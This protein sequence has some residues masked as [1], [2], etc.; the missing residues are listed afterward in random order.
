LSP[1]L[2]AQP[3]A[4]ETGGDRQ[5][6]LGT[7]LTAPPL[8]PEHIVRERLLDVLDAATTRP[9]TLL[10]APTGFGKTTLLAAWARRGTRRSAWLTLTD[11]DADTVRLMA[12]IVAA[13]RR[14]GVD[15]DDD[16]DR[17][18][19]APGSDP[20]GR[21]LP[22]LL[23]GVDEGDPLVLIL[24]D[25]HQ[26][27][28]SPAR[29]LITEFIAGLPERLRV[30]IAT[31]ADPA[32]PLGR[33][34]AVGSM[35]EIRSDR[36][37]FDPEEADRF[38]NGSLGLDL[39]P[40][41]VATLEERTEGWPAGLYLAALG[42]RGHL[43]RARFVAEFAG[44]SRHIVDYLSTEV[45][46]GL[47][48][49]DRSFLLK[50]SILRRLTGPLC[51]A[52]TGMTGSSARLRELQR[53][54]L[55]IVAL[56]E[57]GTWFRFHRLFAQLLRSELADE[58][59][60][61]EPEL[62]R[63]ASAWHADHGPVEAAVEH[64]VAAG[65]RALAGSLMVRSWQ[66]FART[67][68]FQTFERLIALIGDDRGAVA[69]PVAVVEAMMAGLQ[70]RNPTVIG[71]LI[72]KAETSG[73]E[74]PTPDGFPIALL[75]DVVVATFV[76]NDLARQKAAAQRLIEHEYQDPGV[77]GTGRAGL[78][79]ILNLEGDA[80]AALAIL[81]GAD[82]LPDHPNV[83]LY[84]AAARS[85]ATTD[86]GDPIEGERLARASLARAEA[87]GLASSM[88]AGSVWF[89]LGS[90]VNQQGKPRN[91]I[92]PLER[93]LAQWGVP[94]TLHRAQVLID[95]ASVYVAV[96]EPV[97]G[98]TAVREARKI[99]DGTTNA[100]ALPTRLA[101]V[102]KRLRIGAARNLPDS[103]VPSEAEL[104]VLRLLATPLSPR[105]I[106]NELYISINTVKTHTKAL[107]QK[108]GTSSREET[109]RRARELGLL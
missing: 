85:L 86:T 72:T 61:L 21:V 27:T 8:R 41:S 18:L 35:Q 14:A 59:P 42:L 91:A 103:D 39:D 69:G 46:Q 87:W 5:I 98:R 22:R 57:Q 75:A 9:L 108:L 50:T 68:E 79:M 34:R 3:A 81:Q 80:P 99:V 90:A 40:A 6:V 55:F 100:G 101:A 66:D 16:L 37:R 77:V 11:G 94:G 83:S 52:V 30:V 28:G 13:L 67:G 102:E 84:A 44:S 82:L 20:A 97:K 78:G 62:H 95:L 56:D 58:S 49:D 76:A 31:R 23:D 47:A 1:T 12:G 36:L 51:D 32:L 33:L 93:A 89:A 48:A 92:P 54:N 74:G 10:S 4:S 29:G 2:T 65:D 70:G 63:R 24:D 38:L 53:A 88:V 106:G 7:K 71:G 105:G 45:L 25:Y 15:I 26:L 19:V 107:Y 73:W 104:R 64:A 17:D 109:V 43:D 96:G 60:E